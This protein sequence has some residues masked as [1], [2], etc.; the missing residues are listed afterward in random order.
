MDEPS[1]DT[2]PRQLPKVYHALM[3]YVKYGNKMK[4]PFATGKTASNFTYKTGKHGN[5]KVTTRELH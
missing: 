4:N 5:S 2:G 3:I 1:R